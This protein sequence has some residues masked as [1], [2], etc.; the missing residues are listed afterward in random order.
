MNRILESL[1]NNVY[2]GDY[3]QFNA[4]LGLGE[5]IGA[6]P[7]DNLVIR[8]FKRMDSDTLRRY[9]ISPVTVGE[10]PLASQDGMIEVYQSSSE[11]SLARSSI[12]DVA[13]IVPL[14]EVESG[15]FFCLVQIMS[16]LHATLSVVICNL[17][18]AHTTLII[19]GLS[20]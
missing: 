7:Q 9:H 11:I 16:I 3:V 6:G 4:E 18:R 5:I 15:F 2:I 13:F 8:L 19:T 20:L 17:S 12:L 1:Q 10:F 14:K